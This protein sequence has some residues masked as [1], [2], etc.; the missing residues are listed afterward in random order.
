MLCIPSPKPKSILKSNPIFSPSLSL[1]PDESRIEIRIRFEGVTES[2]F[3]QMSKRKLEPIVGMSVD[4]IGTLLVPKD[5]GSHYLNFAR[6]L[7]NNELQKKL[8]QQH[9]LH[10]LESRQVMQGFKVGF[11]KATLQFGIPSNESESRRFWALVVHTAFQPPGVTIPSYSP[12]ELDTLSAALFDHYSTKEP[13]NVLE[14]RDVALRRWRSKHPDVAVVAVTNSDFRIRG[15]L[16][17]LEWISPEVVSPTT[18]KGQFLIDAVISAEDNPLRQKPYPDSILMA[19]APTVEAQTR[20][21]NSS[22]DAVM[23]QWMHV[24]DEYAD[25]D[26]AAAAGC[27]FCPADFCFAFV[28]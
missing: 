19:A 10:I 5:V 23:R 14:S 11:N 22:K 20:L 2:N 25:R 26:A 21:G 1:A 27:M 4:L 16:R 15:V 28:D 13:Y 7:F 24:G 6:R 9:P 18:E 12:S 17:D 8:N 3:P